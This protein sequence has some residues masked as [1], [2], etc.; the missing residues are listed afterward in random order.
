MI[1]KKKL[2]SYHSSRMQSPRILHLITAASLMTLNYGLLWI[3]RL[4]AA[5]EE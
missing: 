2:R 3:M 5:F 1:S 4:E